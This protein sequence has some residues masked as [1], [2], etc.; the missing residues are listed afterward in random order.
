MV[1]GL[2]FWVWGL[3]FMMRGLKLR[4]RALGFGVWGLGF[5]VEGVGK[6]WGLG[7]RSGVPNGRFLE[8]CRFKGVGVTLLVRGERF[9][10]SSS[11]FSIA[12]LRFGGYAL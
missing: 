11:H 8:G 12:H 5:G 10:F 4:V 3:G 1:Q 6:S 9:W 7:L 2:G